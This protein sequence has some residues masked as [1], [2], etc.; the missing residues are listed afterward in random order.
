MNLPVSVV[1][2]V[3]KLGS[4]RGLDSGPEEANALCGSEL[5]LELTEVTCAARVIGNE[6]PLLRTLVGTPLECR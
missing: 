4:R 6:A 5:F 3:G 2:L 1:P